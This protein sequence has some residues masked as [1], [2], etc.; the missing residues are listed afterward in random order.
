M[1]LFKQYLENINNDFNSILKKNYK[2]LY[3]LWSN[4]LEDELIDSLNLENLDSEIILEAISFFKYKIELKNEIT[5]VDSIEELLESK[6]SK[7]YKNILIYLLIKEKF[8]NEISVEFSNFSYPLKIY[9]AIKLTEIQFKKILESKSGCGIYWTYEKDLAE[10][11][12]G[13]DEDG[14]SYVFN[15]E[16]TKD[17]IDWNS[18]YLANLHPT[19]GSDEKEITMKLKSK[20]KLISVSKENKEITI[21]KQIII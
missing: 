10:T 17:N 3:S 6:F 11:H 14:I 18:T 20:I 5:N 8:N 21:N 12:W 13:Y 2:Q 19:T 7:Q 16:T 1:S 4:Y 15:A 9:R